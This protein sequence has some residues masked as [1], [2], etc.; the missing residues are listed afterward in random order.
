MTE[1]RYIH[2]IYVMCENGSKKLNKPTLFCVCQWM[3]NLGVNLICCCDLMFVL[4]AG[5]AL[6]HHDGDYW[7]HSGLSVSHPLSLIHQFIV[8]MQSLLRSACFFLKYSSSLSLYPSSPLCT[9]DPTSNPTPLCSPHIL[10]CSSFVAD[11]ASTATV[12]RSK[13]RFDLDKQH[14]DSTAFTHTHTHTH[15]HARFCS[16]HVVTSH[17][18]ST[19][20]GDKC[21]LQGG[22]REGK[23]GLRQL[24]CC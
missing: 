5:L 14:P 13:K 1:C 9:N 17:C 12:Y 2:F 10:L 23:Y 15:A 16:V 7:H 22:K 19:D 24:L 3:F 18:A 8:F 11:S 6:C 20:Y 4:N 21:L